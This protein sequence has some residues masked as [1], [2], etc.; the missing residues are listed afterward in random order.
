MKLNFEFIPKAAI[1]QNLRFRYKPEWDI[2]RKKVY[3]IY[4]RRCQ[5]CQ[6][7]DCLLDVHEVWDWNEENKIRKLEDAILIQNRRNKI[8]KWEFDK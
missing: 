4:D 2:L 6:K 8:S 7:R 3:E 5:I 1:R